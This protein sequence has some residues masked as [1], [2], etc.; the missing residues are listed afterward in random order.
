MRQE[1]L[2]ECNNGKIS[3]VIH[4]EISSNVINCPLYLA[5]N[6][7]RYTNANQTDEKKMKLIPILIKL[8]MI[9]QE[10]LRSK[11]LN[12]C[13]W[14][15]G[16]SPQKFKKMVHKHAVGISYPTLSLSKY[17]CPWHPPISRAY[18]LNSYILIKL[19]INFVPLL[20]IAASI[21]KCY[22]KHTLE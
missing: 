16:H 22:I 12:G 6:I 11:T 9:F 17:R 4:W 19:K 2:W 8:F 18:F 13:I 3:N 5:E 7:V 14:L 15:Y 10:I 1:P 21:S 20:I